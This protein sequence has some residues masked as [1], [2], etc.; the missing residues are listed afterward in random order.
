MSPTSVIWRTRLPT[1]VVFTTRYGRKMTPQNLVKAEVDQRPAQGSLQSSASWGLPCST[2]IPLATIA[3]RWPSVIV[4]QS[5]A[6]IRPKSP[7]DDSRKC[8]PC[9]DQRAIHCCTYIHHPSLTHHALPRHANPC[10]TSGP[11]SP[12]APSPKTSLAVG[13]SQTSG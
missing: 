12:A 8:A 11:T 10:S 2:F 5:H 3:S 13:G 6:W 7:S 1:L 9:G 4:E